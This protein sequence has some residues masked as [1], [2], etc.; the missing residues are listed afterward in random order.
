[1]VNK[2]LIAAGLNVLL[3]I[4]I[5]Y[6]FIYNKDF[7]KMI[8]VIIDSTEETVRKNMEERFA[9][10][11]DDEEKEFYKTIN[12]DQILEIQKRNKE[13][14]MRIYFAIEKGFIV[15][16][17]VLPSLFCFFLFIFLMFAF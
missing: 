11:E 6:R 1:M 8:Q 15:P 3:F 13:A 2:L 5:Y 4:I 9:E 10:A 14:E 12:I 17:L 16:K 7:N